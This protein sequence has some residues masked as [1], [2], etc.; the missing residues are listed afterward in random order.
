MQVEQDLDK[1][2]TEYFKAPVPES[3]KSEEM[4]TVFAVDTDRDM[5]LVERIFRLRDYMVERGELNF[6]LP[7]EEHKKHVKDKT[8]P[9]QNIVYP[10]YDRPFLDKRPYHP[11]TMTGRTLSKEGSSKKNQ[12]MYNSKKDV[13]LPADSNRLVFSEANREKKYCICSSRNSTQSY[14]QCESECDWFHPECLG[15]DANIVNV[16]NLKFICPMCADATKKQTH[17]FAKREG[18]S[19]I[20]SRTKGGYLAY[21][22]RSA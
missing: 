16:N 7:E 11:Q 19:I 2:D 9:A 15:F 13:R 20:E 10:S 14:L 12:N 22:P 6:V 21:I 18:Y 3:L 4:A 8:L 17:E 1:T 5:N